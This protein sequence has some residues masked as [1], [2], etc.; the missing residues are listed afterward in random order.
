[1][2]SLSSKDSLLMLEEIIQENSLYDVPVEFIDDTFGIDINVTQPSNEI[3]RTTFYQYLKVTF[4][5]LVECQELKINPIKMPKYPLYSF[6]TDKLGDIRVYG[7]TIIQD[8]PSP[9]IHAET[10][11]KFKLILDILKT[12]EERIDELEIMVDI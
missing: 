8:S 7:Q 2:T 11:D 6:N 1:M 3:L 12:H 5:K 9:L 4:R 10:S